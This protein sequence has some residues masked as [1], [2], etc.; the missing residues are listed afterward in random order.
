MLTRR[1]AGV[2]SAEQRELLLQ[3]LARYAD[4]FARGVRQR[5]AR[6]R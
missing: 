4:A 6:D 1:S 5:I 2:L 3:L